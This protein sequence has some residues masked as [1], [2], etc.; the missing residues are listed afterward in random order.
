MSETLTGLNDFTFIVGRWV[1]GLQGFWNILN[2]PV[3]DIIPLRW[4][5]FFADD[6]IKYAIGQYSLLDF[7]LYA[8]MGFV[9]VGFLVKF[10]FNVLPR[11][12]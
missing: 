9:V 2:T 4:L 12:D 11:L 7:I 8:S 6:Y 5:Y 3:V 10:I 1:E